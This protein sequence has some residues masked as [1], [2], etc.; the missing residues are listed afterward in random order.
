[1]PS[2]PLIGLPESKYAR[3]ARHAERDGNAHAHEAAKVGQYLTLALDRN[4]TWEEKVKYFHHALL[5]H[6]HPPPFPDEDVWMFYHQL[7]DCV[8][9]QAGEEALR[10]ASLED[11]QYARR[12]ALGQ[13]R[14]KIE[15]DAETFFARFIPPGDECPEWFNADDFA[16]LKMLRDQWI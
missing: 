13:Q 15:E 4:L 1:M 7:A 3:L 14:S 11:D 16:Q 6:C 2:M 8:R 5:R 10:L 12:L 9:R